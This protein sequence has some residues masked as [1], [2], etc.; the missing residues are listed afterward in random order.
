MRRRLLIGVLALDAIGTTPELAPT[1]AVD[2]DGDGTADDLSQ[3]AA[4]IGQ[5]CVP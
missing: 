1:L 5:C 3:V 4:L 2:S